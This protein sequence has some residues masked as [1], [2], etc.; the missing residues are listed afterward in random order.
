MADGH[1]SVTTDLSIFF[2]LRL[3]RHGGNYKTRERRENGN[4]DQLSESY[5]QVV[6]AIYFRLG[7]SA[8]GG[9]FGHY[10]KIESADRRICEPI[11]FALFAY[12]VVART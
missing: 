3:I 12:F 6:G 11:L 2:Q 9:N 8:C 1:P 7:G 10:P 5:G 4:T